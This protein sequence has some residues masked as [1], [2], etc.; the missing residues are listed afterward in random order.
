[1]GHELFS[2]TLPAF[3]GEIQNSALA[4]SILKLKR[5]LGIRK[6]QLLQ[7]S[8]N[9]VALT[10]TIPVDLPP[11]GN[12]ENLDIRANEP[13]LI[14]FDLNNYPAEAPIVFPDRLGFP[15]DH[16]AHLYV[17]KKGRPPAFCLVRGNLSEWYSNKQVT[18]LCIRVSNWLRDAASGALTE[19]GNQF[20]PVRLEGYSGT[21]IYNYDDIAIIVNEKKSF[22]EN[23]NFAIALFER[24]FLEGRFSFKIVK[25]IRLESLEESLDEFTKEKEKNEGNPSKK[26]YH[27]GYILWSTGSQTFNQYRVHLPDDWNGFIDFCAAYGI[28]TKQVEKQIAENDHNVFVQIPVIVGI[29]RPK[30]IIGFSAEI[31]FINFTIR[32]DTIDVVGESVVNNVPVLFYAHAQPLSRH[33]AE[34]ISGGSVDLGNYA[35]IA[36]CGALGSKVVMHFARSG[37]TNFMLTDPDDL[38]PHNLARHALLG[39]AEGLNKAEALK[40]E[41]K[42]I[43]PN[44]KLPLLISAKRSA[45]SFLNPEISKFFTWILD[46]TA[47]NAF[48]QSLIKT[49]FEAK[50]RI[51]KAFITDFGNLGIA[52]FEGK[53][54]NPR[55]DDLQIMLYSQYAKLPVISSWLKREA[56]NV[57]DVNNLSITVGVGCN[58]ETT[59]LPDDIVSLH[60]AY[61]SAVIKTESQHEQ[62]E[63]GRIYLNE[64][65]TEPFFSSATDRLIVPPLDIFTAFNNISWEVRV[66]S[67]LIT[68]MKEKMKTAMPN[69]TGGVFVGCANHKT[70]TIHVT[71]LIEAPSDSEAN[72]T[73]FYRGIKGLPHR[74]SEINKLTG[75]Q[76]G[77]VGEWHTHPFGPN[78]MS[79]TDL[80]TVGRF[81]KDFRLQNTPLPVF[82][83]IIT[84]THILPYV[85]P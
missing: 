57:S 25:I 34:L 24:N 84:P 65:K 66:S 47:S 23:S 4:D 9:V 51:T 19:D 1:M 69:E 70:K 74:I 33:Q 31:E 54:R 30:K 38:S 21:M 42:V 59:V 67:G 79:V 18:D 7:W 13:V 40:R 44:E 76:L 11:L 55:L 43:Y 29:R 6:L 28:S 22:F 36:G 26:N 45:A 17:A 41:I 14:A 49:D 71:E 20:D 75:N 2:E 16:L 46:F 83:M 12:H 39:S 48:T 52:L 56:E 82:L 78:Q 64:I 5:F 68:Q 58:S 53:G 60:S 80:K 50:I 37:N 62:P 10:V 85:F 32:I 8:D 61:V 27:F 77:Y 35:L 63:D 72:S 15:K 81:K 73:C 3:T